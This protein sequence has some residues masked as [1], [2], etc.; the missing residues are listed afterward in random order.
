MDLFYGSVPVKFV[1]AGGVPVREIRK[2]NRLIYAQVMRFV[3]N[4]VFVVP[5]GVTKIAVDVVAAQGWSVKGGKGGRVQCNIQVTPE[6]VLYVNIG[7]QHTAYNDGTYDASDIRTDTDDLNSRIV[8]AGAGGARSVSQWLGW[9]DCVGGD[10]GGETGADGQG[11]GSETNGIGAKGGTQETGGDGAHYSMYL[12]SRTASK[13]AFGLGGAP[14]SERGGS[15]YGGAGWYGGGGGV[16][17]YYYA[18]SSA[19]GESGAAA[20]GGSSY[21]HPTL[22]SEVVHTQGFQSGNGYVEITVL[23]NEQ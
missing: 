17:G 2:G 14:S 21:T 18:G 5:A 6:Q 13:G 1:R 9:F 7:K 22:C 23:E 10:G 3:D 4:G 19:F 16:D 12:S 20:G 15:G 8:V 11:R